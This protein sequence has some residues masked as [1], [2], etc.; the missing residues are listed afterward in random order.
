MEKRRIVVTGMGALSSLGS[1]LDDTWTALKAG[2]SGIGPITLIDTTGQTVTIA[3][4]V[5]NF[6]PTDYMPEKESRKM[7]RF[8][9]FSCAATSMAMKMAKL[10]TGN[11]DPTRAATIIGVG[12]GGLD[13]IEKGTHTLMEKGARSVPPL[14]IPRII[15]NEAP[16]NVAMM[17]GLQGPCLCITTACSSGTDAIVVAA[18]AIRSNRA[19][20]IVTGGTEAAITSLSLSGFTRLTALTTAY[21]D[22]PTKASRPFDKDRSGFVMGEGAGILILEEYEHAKR[23]GAPIICEYAGGAMTCDAY[24]LTSPAP[25]ANGAIRAFNL[26]LQ[27]AGL[28]PE[29][30]DY[31]NAHGTSTP[32]NDPTETLAI[33]KVFGDHAHKLHISSTKSM[34]GH[35]LGAAG[36]LEAIVSIMAMKHGFVPPTINLDHPGE[37]C[38]LDYTANTGKTA[39]LDIVMSDSLGFGGHNGVVCF[40]KMKE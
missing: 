29:D 20:I 10:E 21:N 7:A 38:D 3:A 14:V 26:C 24:H 6:K 39:E 5:K 22:N 19:D 23:R 25:D 1:N 11:F 37:G 18:D 17:F 35:T 27:D 4:E 15:S 31:L 2:K 12:I 8:T 16:G 40:K 34:M 9:M 13:E 28:K 33:K 36:G 30:I 32:V